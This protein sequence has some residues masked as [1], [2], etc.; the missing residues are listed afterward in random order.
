MRNTVIIGVVLLIAVGAYFR[1][2]G[3][4]GEDA[5]PQADAPAEATPS[6]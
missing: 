1:T 4:G 3:S 2:A 5:L 6:G